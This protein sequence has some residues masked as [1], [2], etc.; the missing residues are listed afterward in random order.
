MHL[1][2]ECREQQYGADAE[3]GCVFLERSLRAKGVEV[4]AS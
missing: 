1:E 3:L 4:Q 2:N